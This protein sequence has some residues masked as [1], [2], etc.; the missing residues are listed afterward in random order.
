M[1]IVRTRRNCITL[2]PTPEKTVGWI[3]WGE[4]PRKYVV[5]VQ[6]ICH[7]KMVNV[8]YCKLILFRYEKCSR[9]S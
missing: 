5:V 8:S 2:T 3:V 4:E 7:I 9:G 1:G 6:P